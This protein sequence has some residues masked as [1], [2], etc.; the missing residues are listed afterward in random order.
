MK[1]WI[2]FGA[3]VWGALTLLVAALGVGIGVLLDFTRWMLSSF[4]QSLVWLW[5]GGM[6]CLTLLIG[7]ALAC[8]V[9]GYFVNQMVYRK[10]RQWIDPKA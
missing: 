1:G 7:W 3:L 5:A 10:F 8:T 4:P 9:A 2:K 6:I